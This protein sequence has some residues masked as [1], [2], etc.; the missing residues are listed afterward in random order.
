SIAFVVRGCLRLYRIDDEGEE[1]VLRFAVE[2]WWIN[3]AESFRT[4]LPAQG[5]IEALEDTHVL[6]WAHADWER[7]KRDIPAFYALDSHLA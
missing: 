4:G 6:L 3:D 1:H 2:N 5:N 7:L